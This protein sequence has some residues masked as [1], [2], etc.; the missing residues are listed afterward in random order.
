MVF[1]QLVTWTYGYAT[2]Q[3]TADLLRSNKSTEG[4]PTL[5]L[6][7]ALDAGH[8]HP[9]MLELPSIRRGPTSDGP[10]SSLSSSRRHPSMREITRYALSWQTVKR[11]GREPVMMALGSGLLCS[12]TPLG[13]EL[14][15]QNSPSPLRPLGA[16]MEMLGPGL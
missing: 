9:S 7:S 3:A 2:I 4:P 15:R 10:S 14:F 6:S 5:S 8:H 11:L 12:L 1:W 16:T 13:G